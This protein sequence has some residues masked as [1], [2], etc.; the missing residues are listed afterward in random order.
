MVKVQVKVSGT[1][2]LKRLVCSLRLHGPVGLGPRL[3]CVRRD[4]LVEHLALGGV[5]QLK[6]GLGKT[7]AS[8]G[9]RVDVISHK[10]E[11]IVL[12]SD[13]LLQLLLLIRQQGSD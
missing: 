4:H 11:Q 13:E 8:G 3:R 2:Q 1:H 10:I 5:V 9:A 7:E 6:V 12:L